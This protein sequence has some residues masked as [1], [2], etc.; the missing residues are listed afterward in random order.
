[1]DDQALTASIHALVGRVE[2]ED[3][4]RAVETYLNQ[5]PLIEEFK[6]Q[7]ILAQRLETVVARL[8]RTGLANEGQEL[9]TEVRRLIVERD[10]AIAV[11]EVGRNVQSAANA[12][13]A[14]YIMT[15]LET[16]QDTITECLQVLDPYLKGQDIGVRTVARTIAQSIE[17]L[18]SK[19]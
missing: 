14:G 19:T 10:Q 18:R 12:Q 2:P 17:A 9:I 15:A 1:M 8:A 16:R 7:E 3:V 11:A 6:D 4:R 13:V 5:R